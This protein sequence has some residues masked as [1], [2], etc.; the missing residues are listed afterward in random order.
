MAI[1]K[2]IHCC[3]FGGNQMNDLAL[4]CIE[5]WKKYLPEYEIRIW[6]EETF[7][8]ESVRYTKEAY[9]S[10]KWAFI[11]DY[12]RLWALYNEGGVYLDTDVEVLKSIDKFLEHGAFSGFES[13][14][15]IPT[16]IMASEKGNK[17]I[18]KLL[19]Y[20][21]DRSFYDSNNNPILVPNTK[22]ITDMSLEQ[23]LKLNGKYQVIMGDVHIYPKEYFAPKSYVTEEINITKNTYCIHHF[24]GSWVDKSKK[25][26]KIL[27]FKKNIVKL[28]GEDSYMYLMHVKN[29]II[30]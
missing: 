4:K 25:N 21:K 6:N 14:Y 12:V 30:K 15:M 20:Y 22:I 19:E 27:K 24:S 29:K 3:W 28:I 18:E 23:G 17:W 7:D 9:E 2:I 1:P 8:I 26:D 11:T 10:K 16:G 13:K 5:S